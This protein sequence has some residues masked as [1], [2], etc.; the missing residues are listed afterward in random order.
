MKTYFIS[1]TCIYY[2]LIWKENPFSFS[3]LALLSVSL[4][5]EVAFY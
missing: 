3:P 5:V 2:V 4:L 1:Q